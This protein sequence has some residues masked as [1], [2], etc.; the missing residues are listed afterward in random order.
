MMLRVMGL[1]VPKP[2]DAQQPSAVSSTSSVVS[3]ILNSFQLSSDLDKRELLK[4]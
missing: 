1:V 2:P 4:K 3:R